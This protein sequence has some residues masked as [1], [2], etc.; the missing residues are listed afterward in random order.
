MQPTISIFPSCLTVVIRA[1]GQPRPRL[2]RLL[3]PVYSGKFKSA[4]AD[5]I[6]VAV[7][8]D[9]FGTLVDVD[10]PEDPAAAV[11]SALCDRGVEVPSDW[12]AAYTEQHIDAPDGAEVLLPVHVAAALRS[13]G[14]DTPDSAVRN[15]VV[16]AFDPAV[17][18]R[19]GAVDAIAAAAEAGP[20]GLLSNCAVPELVGR[21]L[22]RST[23]DRDAFDAIVTS[24][25]CG[26]RKPHPNIFRTA[27]DELGVAPEAL[28]HV[29]DD[30]ATDGG[31]TSLGGSFLDVSDRDLEA[32]ATQLRREGVPE[33]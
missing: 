15:A 28:C 4:F 18:T 29:G 9:L 2:S 27:A 17:D 20:V 32:L 21:T 22:I 12:Q 30:P 13:R 10:R 33:E 7:T 11:A 14:V 5:S 25:G 24:S 23:L 6:V 8:F 16:A 26:W 1:V 31:I 19:A 3:V